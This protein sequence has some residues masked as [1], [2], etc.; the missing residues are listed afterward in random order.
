[1]KRNYSRFYFGMLVGLTF[2]FGLFTSSE[3]GFPT[4]NSFF[5]AFLYWFAIVLAMLYESESQKRME[6]L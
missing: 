4:F 5:A 6:F 1:M 2:I 3:F